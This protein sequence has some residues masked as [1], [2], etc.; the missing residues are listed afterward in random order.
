MW[1]LYC[2]LGAVHGDLVHEVSKSVSRGPVALISSTSSGSSPRG[3]PGNSRCP[4][5]APVGTPTGDAVNSVAETN[6]GDSSC[7]K[8]SA[9]NTSAHV[10]A[11]PV[12]TG[13]D[14]PNVK[15]PVT[16]SHQA[17]PNTETATKGD[18]SHVS[19][20]SRISESAEP[21]GISPPQRSSTPIDT[22][23][24]EDQ[25]GVSA[26]ET[27]ARRTL[28]IS[29]N[30]SLTSTKSASSPRLAPRSASSRRL[31]EL[32]NAIE[33]RS[34]EQLR[35]LSSLSS[36]VKKFNRRESLRRSNTN[37]RSGPSTASMH[38]YSITH[39]QTS[40]LRRVSTRDYS[41][42]RLQNCHTEEDTPP[43]PDVDKP[44][45]PL[46][47][48]GAAEAPVAFTAGQAPLAVASIAGPAPLADP[49]LE[50]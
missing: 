33:D 17:L 10:P 14:V 19:S 49:K 2:V 25:P 4:S 50:G 41:Q 31:E 9:N 1:Y 45:S 37:D 29:P 18:A 36:D 5:S 23:S 30:A 26:D 47:T 27:T 42:P 40:R 15:S 22:N 8:A 34:M 7:G 11:A 21:L 35:T 6:N 44:A 38:Q 39:F 13:G 20:E 16:S 28:H 48:T 12:T 24:H 32:L 43:Q 3:S 46:Q